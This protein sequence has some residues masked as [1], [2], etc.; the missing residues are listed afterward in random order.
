ML[1]DLLLTSATHT[2]MSLTISVTDIVIYKIDSELHASD[3]RMVV[4]HMGM[5][6][7]KV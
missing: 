6:Y 2:I 1:P 4:G 7:I 5:G 3:D